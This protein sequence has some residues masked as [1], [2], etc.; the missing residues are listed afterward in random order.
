MARKSDFCCSCV[1][2]KGAWITGGVTMFLSLAF[3]ALGF[4]LIGGPG[5]IAGLIYMHV[6]VVFLSI[7]CCCKTKN[8]YMEDDDA[9]D[10]ESS[11]NT[12]AIG[13]NNTTVNNT[14]TGAGG[15]HGGPDG[16]QAPL[17][18]GN[19]A[20]YPYQGP[21]YPQAPMGMA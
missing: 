15:Q 5:L 4:F 20:P 1:T 6:G 3:I 13:V 21:G 18:G 11:K 12:L 8:D 2:R 14:N 9:D 19:G 7:A 16:D 10:E 17:M